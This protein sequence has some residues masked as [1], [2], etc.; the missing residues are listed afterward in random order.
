MLDVNDF[1]L[2]FVAFITCLVILTVGKNM[3]KRRKL[4]PG[5][6]PLPILGNFLQFQSEGLI[7]YFLKMSEK[8]GPVFTVYMGS[9]PT[10]VLCGY[11]AV[12]EAL[13]DHG[14]NFGGRGNIPVFERLF[15]KSGLV[16][17]NGEAWKQ[18]KQFSLLT[19]RDFGMGKK[20]LEEPIQREAQHLVDHFRNSNEQPIDPT[21]IMICASSNIIAAIIMGT[22][23]DY[24]DKKWMKILH[25]MHEAF[26]VACSF[27]GQ[28]YDLFPKIMRILPGPHNGVFKMLQELEDVIKERVKSNSATLDRNCPR[29]YIDCFLIRMDQE[30]QNSKAPFNTENLVATVFDM[31]LGGAESTGI[32]LIFGF[33]ILLKYPEIQEKLHEEVDQV[34]GRRREPMIEDRNNMPYM[35]ATIH[36]I[37]RFSNVL[38]LGIIRSTTKEVNYR[39]YH[40]PQGTDMLPILGT[41]LRDP[42][43]FE[44]PE[45][46]NLKHFLDEN[47]KFKKNNGFLAFS[48]GK[49]TCI[50]ESLVRMQLFIYFATI[51]Q[52]FKL[53]TTV[54]PKD[55]DI[56]PAE[57]GIETLP[58]SFKISFIP[59]E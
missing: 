57:C 16:L 46:I 21:N 34:I 12:K 35:N 1:A 30:K 18:L 13:V 50:G 23:Y 53:K 44:T 2:I 11:Q 42:S 36:E 32:T 10:V 5:P 20:S 28:L 43:Q 52:K 15:N 3:W 24:N 59:R 22:R 27:W 56:N 51:L 55:L 9:R 19:L 39:G 25:D 4:P 58:P 33:L 49:R 17:A 54:D 47:G 26:S 48:A 41:V 37:Q 8:Y 31:F 40:I 7:P 29:D 45:E 6:F 14:D 38:P